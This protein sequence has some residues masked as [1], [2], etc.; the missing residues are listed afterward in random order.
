MS[1]WVTRCSKCEREIPK[2]QVALGPPPLDRLRCACPFCGSMSL[3][4][5]GPTITFPPNVRFVR[6]DD[7][8]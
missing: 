8:E 7:A 3:Q 4:Q 6:D 2:G 1:D 5:E